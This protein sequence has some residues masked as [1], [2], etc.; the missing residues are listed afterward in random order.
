MSQD[1]EERVQR[2]GQGRSKKAIGRT[3][4]ISKDPIPQIVAFRAQGKRPGT[5]ERPLK[6]NGVAEQE[7]TLTMRIE[8]M[9]DRGGGK[10]EG[11]GK[12][13]SSG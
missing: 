13:K 2:E 8:K 7:G 11:E 1:R 6:G 5:V 10:V 9:K 12:K 3:K 4:K